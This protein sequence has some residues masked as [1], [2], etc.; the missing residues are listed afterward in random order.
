MLSHFKTFLAFN[1]LNVLEKWNTR[2]R[3]RPPSCCRGWRPIDCLRSPELENGRPRIV[4]DVIIYASS[5][6]KNCKFKK[7]SFSNI[8]YFFLCASKSVISENPNLAIVFHKN[9]ENTFETR[10]TKGF[11]S[12]ILTLTLPRCTGVLRSQYSYGRSSRTFK[13]LP[14]EKYN[15]YSIIFQ[16]DLNLNAFTNAPIT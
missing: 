9:H 5:L 7:I 15:L 13:V 10:K 16:V 8:F 12:L 14:P 1:L 6:L 2:P 3:R 4:L 11:Q